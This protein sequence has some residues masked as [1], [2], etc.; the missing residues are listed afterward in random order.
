MY[1]V[2]NVSRFCQLGQNDSF[3]RSHLVDTQL[4]EE[5]LGG[6]VETRVIAYLQLLTLGTVRYL[7]MRPSKP[8]LKI[9]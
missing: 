7:K 4:N 3:K 5:R 1:D 9:L 8:L 2:V 6:F